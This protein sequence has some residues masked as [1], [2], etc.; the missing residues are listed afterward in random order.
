MKVNGGEL[1]DW[2]LA[3]FHLFLDKMEF[4][5]QFELQHCWKLHGIGTGNNRLK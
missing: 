3:D 1:D 5:E 4:L 2:G